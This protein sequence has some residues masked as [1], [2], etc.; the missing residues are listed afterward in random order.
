MALQPAIVGLARVG[1]T[2]A[3][4]VSP[5][6]AAQRAVRFVVYVNA[7]DRSHLVDRY[8]ISILD[9]LNE[10]PNTCTF[11]GFGFTPAVAQVVKITY[12]DPASKEFEGTITGIA[13]YHDRLNN[14]IVY[15]IT[16]TDYTLDADADLVTKAYGSQSATAIAQDIATNYMS[17]FTQVNIAAGLPTVSAI[18]F[19][20]TPVS[21]ALRQLCDAF[22]GDTFIDYD[23]DVHIFLT[24]T[25]VTPDA[26]T[27]SNSAFKTLKYTSDARIANRILVEGMGT[28]TTA[29][30]SVGATSIPV[31]T[32]SMFSASGGLATI[33]NQII[34]Y[35]TITL[36]RPA[37]APNASARSGTGLTSGA[38]YGYEFTFGTASGETLPSPLG[39]FTAGGTTAAP[40]SAPIA[41]SPVTGG[42]IDVGAHDYQVTFGTASGET[43]PSAISAQV[44]TGTISPPG[45]ASAVVQG[46][47]GGVGYG[48]GAH[49]PSAGD[50]VTFK[51]TATNSVGETTVGAT[52]VAVT[53]VQFAG[54]PG[55]TT[56]II[57]TL[58]SLPTG[59]TGGYLYMYANGVLIN[60]YLF[61]WVQN[62][63]GDIGTIGP[64]SGSPPGSNTASLQ[65]VPLTAIP[66][67][68]TNVTSRKLYRRF[69]GTGT[70]K[71]VTTIANNTATTYTDT[72]TNA[73]L[74][75]AAPSSN[76]AITEQARLAGILTGPTG[77]T[78]RKVYRT[79]ANGS[80]LK[81]L[82]TIADNSTTTYTDSAADGALGADIPTTDTSGL[83]A[84][85]QILLGI[86]A[87]GTGS[88]VNAI[89]IGDAINI[90]IQRDDATSQATYGIRKAYIQ[91]RR[92]SIAGAQ[93]RGDA[94]LTLRKNPFISG[95]FITTDT[96]VRSGRQITITVA[97]WS[98]SGNY[99]I[100]KVRKFFKEGDQRMQR[101]V[102]FAS[103]TGQ[104][105]LYRILRRLRQD[106]RTGA[107]G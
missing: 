36:V 86:P 38:V 77:T 34:S 43:T 49:W 25:A 12:A 32:V 101:E 71:L 8:S 1:N 58:P 105:D 68:D 64:D 60:R 104:S 47:G 92:L 24:D 11:E 75:A 67:G 53:A 96:K 19:K 56:P 21:T 73:S 62:A 42:S 37:T 74:G 61:T 57:V 13:E 7:V 4:Y 48:S 29:N 90:L 28:I 103:N 94:E 78:T 23:K 10:L 93:A 55:F 14:R 39:S 97:A 102:S 85:T 81:L 15:R 80:A 2:R 33:G 100:T 50:S 20:M 82:T 79:G 44:T 72:S 16:C 59:A 99:V 6:L 88:I 65:T 87:S 70:F 46:S 26:I 91:D 3:G 30:V 63:S 83:S 45:A 106:Q 84:G 51:C 31:T 27:T 52:S 35:S 41:G 17:G 98:I 69:N 89:N 9:D 66:T 22:G 107:G 95:S 5:A 40:G 76:T 18:Q 54:F